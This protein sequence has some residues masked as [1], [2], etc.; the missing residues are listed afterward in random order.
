LKDG[1]RRLKKDVHSILKIYD[2][3]SFENADLSQFQFAISIQGKGNSSVVLRP[4][5]QGRRLNLYFDDVLE[6]TPGAAT[7]ADIDALFDFTQA[8]LPVTRS[9]PARASL[10]THCA[11][12]IS[13]SA[14]SALLP[15]TLYF[16]NYFAAALHLFRTHPHVI[17]N[18][19]ICRLI[20]EKLGPIY[21]PDISQ[22]L[23]LG[24][25]EAEQTK[26]LETNCDK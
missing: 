21:G 16:G 19:W 14:A 3:N 2:Q 15:L 7:A 20:F 12:G 11:A 9:E 23:M 22:A 8:W 25:K 4:D 18:S 5:F 17:P 26:G 1:S 6:G 13:R 10:V 24:K